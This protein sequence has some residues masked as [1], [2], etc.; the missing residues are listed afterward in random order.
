MTV[1]LVGA[2][3]GDPALLT[4]RGA[5]LLAR[6][7]VVVFDRLSASALVELA[8]AT[9]ERVNVGKSPG[10]PATAQD[11][12]NALLID[13]GRQGLRVVRLKGGD[14]F[15][16]GRGG[17]ECAALAAAGVAFEVVPGVTSA[18]AAPAYAGVPLTYRG[19]TSSVTIV[20]G[21][22]TPETPASVDWDAIAKLGGTIVV[23]MG[24]SARGEI[25]TKL[26]AGGL[27]GAT[28]VTA[29]TWGTRFEQN[30]V[31]TTLAEL[32]DAEVQ[33]PVTIV[34]GAVAALAD[35]L[36]WFQLPLAGLSVVVA[37]PIGEND[38]GT[39][40]GE[41]VAISTRAVGASVTNV[42]TGS[43]AMPTDGG[44]ALRA[45]I[46]D[47]PRAA[48]VTFASA[49]SVEAFAA[50]AGADFAFGDALV[51]V[52][53]GATDH[54]F[55]RAFARPAD[56]V[57]DPPNGS[58]LAAAIGEA[59]DD[60]QASVLVIGAEDGRPE[61]A[62]GL[63]G[64]GWQPTA[65]AAYRLGPPPFALVSP[66]TAVAGAAAV[67]CTSPS[68][69]AFLVAHAALISSAA[70]VIAIGPTTADTLSKAGVPAERLVTSASPAVDDVVKALLTC[71]S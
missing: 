48:W 13:R 26:M 68:A 63:R 41:R 18:I 57:A 42:V 29:V 23:L 3:P 65:V 5:D 52:V 6:A 70:T 14:P 45:A 8:P 24:A 39:S 67:V 56:L 61:L 33:P 44:A 46:A 34:I 66:R 50:S 27:D 58:A 60:G 54:A 55:E 28:P 51:G 31:R 16:F 53:G 12:I 11:D 35:D 71:L 19:M 69:A 40:F 20:T 32:G 38:D 1:H 36:A 43:R 49:A 62:D 17:E 9:A 25:A 30:V 2:G 47:T 7:D 4:V 21:H 37:A 64:A 10:A 22:D 59:P 15:L